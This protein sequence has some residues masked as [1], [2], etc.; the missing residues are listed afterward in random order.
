[1]TDR[2]TVF[3]ETGF[4]C[5]QPTKKIDLLHHGKWLQS[6]LTENIFQLMSPFNGTKWPAMAKRVSA[7][8][9]ALGRGALT[10]LIWHESWIIEANSRSQRALE[11]M[12]NAYLKHAFLESNDDVQ[13]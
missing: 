12:A 2:S 10:Q 9:P 7:D 3:L 1:M 5:R 4:S 13:R 6:L 8:D 11:A